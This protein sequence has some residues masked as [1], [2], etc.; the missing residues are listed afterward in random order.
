M[1]LTQVAA[2]MDSVPQADEEDLRLELDDDLTSVSPGRLNSGV[3]GPQNHMAAAAEAELRAGGHTGDL[4]GSLPI[5]QLQEQPAASPSVPGAAVLHDESADPAPSPAAPADSATRP[6]AL[7]PWQTPLSSLRAMLAGRLQSRQSAVKAAAAPHASV[8]LPASW[9]L[10]LFDIQ[11]RHGYSGDAGNS[12]PA[13][14][15]ATAAAAAAPP[16][17]AEQQG[18]PCRS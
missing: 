15:A 13:G 1:G 8:Q 11:M 3:S 16:R 6:A 5:G 18:S 12:G 14:R 17:S 2:G 9:P 4:A 10:S 7:S